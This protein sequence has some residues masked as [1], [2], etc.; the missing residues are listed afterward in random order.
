MAISIIV[1]SFYQKCVIMHY[2]LCP[3]ASLLYIAGILYNYVKHIRY[4]GTIICFLEYNTLVE[5]KCDLFSVDTNG[6]SYYEL[7]YIYF[8]DLPA[9]IINVKALWGLA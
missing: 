8:A 3:R 4:N 9:Y 2:V 7:V 6:S 5:F 1:Q